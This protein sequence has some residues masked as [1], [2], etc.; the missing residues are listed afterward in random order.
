HTTSSKFRERKELGED[1][2]HEFII[3]DKRLTFSIIELFFNFKK[4]EKCTTLCYSVFETK[5]HDMFVGILDGIQLEEMIYKFGF[6]P[7]IIIYMS[8]VYIGATTLNMG[9]YIPI[10]NTNN[11]I[12]GI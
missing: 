3:H 8:G 5:L 11:P 7:S 12:Y 10:N 2:R 4:L 1:R 9:R 6:I